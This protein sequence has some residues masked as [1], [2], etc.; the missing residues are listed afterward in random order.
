[1]KK[2]LPILLAIALAAP[3]LADVTI[4]AAEYPAAGSGV[5]RVTV[6][7]TGD[8]IVRGVALVL[9]TESGDAE[10]A[11]TGDVTMTNFNTNIDYFFTN[12]TGG[13]VGDTPDGE[14]HPIAK[15]GEAGAIDDPAGS[16][17]QLPAS[18]FVLSTGYLDPSEAQGGL[19]QVDSF[20]DI[21]YDLTVTST[22]SVELDSL[23][24]EV[25]GEELGGITVSNGTGNPAEL[26]VAGVEC[27]DG[28]AD[29]AE[30]V[31]A[32]SPDC[33]CYPRQCHGDAD[34]LKVGSPFTGYYYVSQDDL[35]I[36]ISA[37][38][39]KNPPQGGGLSGDQGCADFNHAKVGSPFT[40][41]YRVSQDDLNI[42]IA[43]WQVKEAPQGSGVPGDCL[44]GN[45][46]P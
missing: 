1:M 18:T 38:Q 45:E 23:R 44:P 26:L 32:G 37:W 36:L 27:Y 9:T 11:A 33:W 6:S 3:A 10:L 24:G 17:N 5:L 41:Y 46:T 40:G 25:V 35:N 7:A 16:G 8:A 29:Y 31:D 28:M 15:D 22:V 43:T 19:Y 21:T 42:L 34:G 12:G 30:W 4:S 39:V 14:G 2:V 13:V 20:F